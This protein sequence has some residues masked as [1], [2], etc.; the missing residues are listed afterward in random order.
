MTDPYADVVPDDE[1]PKQ[2]TWR[3]MT[4][5]DRE[6]LRKLVAGSSWDAVHLELYADDL[7]T[8]RGAT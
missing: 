1:M 8:M 3:S 2:L 4:D 6:T 5:A 7:W